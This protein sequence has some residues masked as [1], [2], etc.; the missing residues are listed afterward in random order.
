[1]DIIEFLSSR[2]YLFQSD[3]PG[4][5]LRCADD[6]L[7]YRTWNPAIV[8]ASIA[9]TAPFGLIYAQ[10]DAERGAEI[11][12]KQLKK[13]WED[14]GCRPEALVFCTSQ[15][16]LNCSYCIIGV[17]EGVTFGFP[18]I[19]QIEKAFRLFPLQRV[20]IT[21][22][23]PLAQRGELEEILEWLIGRVARCDLV[24]NGLAWDDSLW[25]LL[26]SC[27]ENFDLRIRLTLS[28][29]LSHMRLTEFESKI[30]PQAVDHPEVRINLGFLPNHAGS[31]LAGFF[32]RVNQ[33]DLPAHITVAPFCLM[34]SQFSGPVAFDGENY[35][36]EMLEMIEN[37]AEY[38]DQ[39]NFPPER[40]LGGFLHEPQLSGCKRGKIAVTDQGYGL[41]H[42]TLRDGEFFAGPLEAALASWERLA[43]PCRECEY[44][45][46]RCR[47][48]IQSGRCFHLAP[49]CYGCPMIYSCLLRC[50]YICNVK[51][52]R[53]D[54]N[55]DLRCLAH[56]LLQLFTMWLWYRKRSWQDIQKEINGRV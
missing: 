51:G 54:C 46:D 12:E 25:P 24:T 10:A 16:N 15:C 38:L 28:E 1:M 43:K 49:G 7:Q 32:Q 6:V 52:R 33:L 20:E 56:S 11:F 14:F 55:P 29:G 27:G 35:I 9:T 19:E 53:A 13:H 34:E 22:G 4:F 37:P 8:P 47:E 50:P 39:V 23:E 26:R 3:E 18:S 48:A 36:R 31:G 40:N 42:M 30:L 44:Y 45:P 41:C 17:R 2:G 5:F 21:G